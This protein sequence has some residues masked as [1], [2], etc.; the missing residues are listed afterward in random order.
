MWVV[1]GSLLQD[2]DA[3]QRRLDELVRGGRHPG[4]PAHLA[5]VGGHDA[6]QD[7]LDGD[8]LAAVLRLQVLR[9]LVH[10]RLRHQEPGKDITKPYPSALWGR[11]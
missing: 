9:Q 4:S 5:H 11:P 8:S 2:A 6:R 1:A 10:V 3:F 7:A